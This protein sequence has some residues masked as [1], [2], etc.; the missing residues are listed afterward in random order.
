MLQVNNRIQIPE[1]ELRFS[2]AQSPG[3]GGQN[4]NK[5]NTKAILHW[6]LEESA[7]LPDD[8][9]RRFL[10][11]FGNRVN[12]R[13]EFVIQSSRFRERERNIRDCRAKLRDMLAEVAKPPKRRIPTKPT[14]S[15]KRR[16]LEA[17]RKQSQKKQWRR[18]PSME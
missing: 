2:Y 1:D 6:N 12:R 11:H 15:S 3:P 17:K 4:V 16:R 8:V 10:K 13:G 14:K 7:E 5:V 18:P 9:R